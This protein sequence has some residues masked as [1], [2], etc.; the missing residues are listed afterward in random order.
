MSGRIEH[1]D[2][3][4]AIEFAVLIAEE[5]NKGKRSLPVPA[6]LRAQFGVS[7]I[8]TAALGRLRRAI[9]SDD[10]FRSRIAAGAVPELV[11][12]IGLLWLQRPTGWEQQIDELLVARAAEEDD[13][14]LR[15]S[16][17]RAE[18]R[19]AAAEQVA[20]RSRAEVIQRDT[21]L[22]ELRARLDEV[23]A[24]L[25]KADDAV[26]ELRAELVDVRN[27]ARHARDRE[28][29]LRTR[30]EALRASDPSSEAP[31][32]SAVQAPLVP[33]IDLDELGAIAAA[34]Q[35]LGNR[36]DTLA[37]VPRGTTAQ[38]GTA[39]VGSP[40][41]ARRPIRLPG[42]VI[43]SSAVAAE[44]LLR[45]D[46]AVVVDGY[47]VAMLGWPGN[48]LEEQRRRLLDALENAARRFGADVTVVFDGAAVVGAHA[49]RR[50]MVRVA[51][52]PAGVTADD[53]IRDEVRR[54]PANRSVVVVTND[55]E[56]VNDV[57]ALGANVVPSNALLAVV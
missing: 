57:R 3:R 52:S 31:P 5:A 4:T 33:A 29:A 32:V 9:E 26:A 30:L 41:A 56:I 14:D 46:A 54:L 20:A 42:G 38:P 23:V 1:R 7:R 24:D 50:R 39:P 19:R 15:A 45:S 27:E 48:R 13:A 17:R 34:V 11:D 40:G 51:Y 10:V 49:D 25:A 44:F 16:L 18:R 55:A 43:A 8:P 2:L 21:A 22:T 35:E 37:A 28:T 6:E 47:N 53:V 12:Q 36:L